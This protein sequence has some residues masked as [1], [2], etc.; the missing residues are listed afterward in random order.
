MSLVTIE[1]KEHLA[2]VIKRRPSEPEV[3]VE[4]YQTPIGRAW[5]IDIRA[6]G[7]LKEMIFP[8]G[9]DF[10]SVLQALA[11]TIYEAIK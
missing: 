3:C 11:P 7:K 1:G 9:V 8:A 2:E 4:I 6:N 5:V 10:D